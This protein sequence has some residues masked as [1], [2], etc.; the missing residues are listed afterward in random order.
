MR[1]IV[2]DLMSFSRIKATVAPD[3]APT[4]FFMR[5]RVK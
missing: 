3:G 5:V 2:T 1:T 4:A